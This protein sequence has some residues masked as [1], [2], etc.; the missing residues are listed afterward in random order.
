MINDRIASLI[1]RKL[2]GEITPDELQELTDH[3]KTHPGDQ[4]FEELLTSYWNFQP[5][6]PLTDSSADDHFSRILKLADEADENN[7][8]TDGIV[9][10]VGRTVDEKRRVLIRRISVAITVAAGIALLMWNFSSS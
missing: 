1:A 4:Y 10:P 9:I 7:E 5:G 6:T 8:P 2:S 3:F